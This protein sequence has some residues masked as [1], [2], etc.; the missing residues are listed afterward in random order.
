MNSKNPYAVTP[1]APPRHGPLFVRSDWWILALLL[2]A[3]PLFGTLAAL[4]SIGGN[5]MGAMI[6]GAMF[7][8]PVG[9]VTMPFV[10]MLVRGLSPW[11]VAAGVLAPTAFAAWVGGEI[12]LRSPLGPLSIAMPLTGLVYFLSAAAVRF[13]YPH[14]PPEPGVCASCGY[15]LAGLKGAVCPECGARSDQP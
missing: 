2:I 7:G 13:V 3:G 4:A 6:F 5:M 9:V 12:G 8:L 15:A 11:L 14:E 10:F 1:P